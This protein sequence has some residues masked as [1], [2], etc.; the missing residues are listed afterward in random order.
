MA[1]NLMTPADVK[2]AWAIIPTPSKPNASDWR[3]EDTVDLDETARVVE[4]L[5]ETGID[6]ILSMGTL[7]EAAT[8]TLPEKRSY[9]STLVESARGRVPVFVGTTTLNTRDT[10]ALTREARDMGATGTMLGIP[11]WCAP[12]LEVAVQFYRDIAEAVPDM[13]IAIYA[14]PEAFKFEF[15]RAFWAQVAEL[16]QVVT[17][18][19]I[20]IAAL[21]PDLAAVRGRIKLLPIDFDYYAAARIDDSVDAFWSSGAACD[22]LVTVVLRDLVAEARRTNDWSKARDL[23]HKLGPTAAPLFP[24]GSFK[25]FST[26]NIGLEKARM[27]A[28]GWMKAG[29]IRPPYHIVPEEYLIGARRS[30]EMWA[31]VGRELR[32]AGAGRR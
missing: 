31:A 13:N 22:P 15:P 30:G 16:P 1:R 9:M 7:G 14:N 3:A 32:A 27:D 21:V 2:G 4:A 11:M 23:A 26:Y 5:I 10:V 6:G 25:A 28:A 19:Y 8:L 18:K 20:G 24:N 12:S 17:A 29:P